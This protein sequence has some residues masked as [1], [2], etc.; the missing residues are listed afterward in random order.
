MAVQQPWVR[1]RQQTLASPVRDLLAN[2]L[3]EDD[4]VRAEEVD[5]KRDAVVPTEEVDGSLRGSRIYET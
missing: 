1:D 3:S 4:Q 5:V 2:G